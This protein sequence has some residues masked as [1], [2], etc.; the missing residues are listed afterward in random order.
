MGGDVLTQPSTVVGKDSMTAGNLLSLIA[1][2]NSMSLQELV[3][4]AQVAPKKLFCL[5][6]ELHSAKLIEIQGADDLNELAT[7]FARH[8]TLEFDPSETPY[9]ADRRSLLDELAAR[10]PGSKVTVSQKG[11]SRA[12]AL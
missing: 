3:V 6:K 7:I 8:Q 5:L 1:Q 10:R 4:A 12:L 2:F 9:L 11:F